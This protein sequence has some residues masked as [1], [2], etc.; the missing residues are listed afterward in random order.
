[1]STPENNIPT[2]GSS[3]SSQP[4][5]GAAK[6]PEFG[7]AP[8]YGQQAQYGQDQQP[9]AQQP[10]GQIPPYGQHQQ[11]GPQP[12]PYGQPQQYG[13]PQPY[14]QQPYGAQPY[15]QQ[16]QP[17]RS[18]LAITA[19]V[20]GIISLVLCW[21][22]ILNNVIFIVAI[23]G[24][25]FGI[26]A[27]VMVKKNPAKRRGFG[28][29]LAGLILSVVSIAGV[30]ITQS[31][32]SKA[33]DEAS[34]ALDDTYS[35]AAAVDDPYAEREASASAEAAKVQ[36]NLTSAVAGPNDYEGKPTII[37]TYTVT[38]GTDKTYNMYDVTVD[39]FQNG[40]S[41]SD[42]P[43]FTENP[44]GYDPD[45]YNQKIQPGA[46]GTVT[47]AFE[48]SDT[49]SNVTV[50]ATPSVDFHEGAKVTQEFKLQ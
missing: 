9:N 44:E 30:L 18:G 42:N 14:G 16:V 46:T 36:V 41:L 5:N 20:L 11:P 35:S 50:E 29:A 12:Q 13:Q 15:G 7:A 24:L 19:L 8:Q 45:S 26:I 40:T 34:K 32:Y 6:Q 37:V 27:M 38:N 47:K 1:M 49:T 28:M 43:F 39:A 3:D 17:K 25:V 23:V 31:I 4:A 48:L 10:S 22:P 21:V 2:P 33:L